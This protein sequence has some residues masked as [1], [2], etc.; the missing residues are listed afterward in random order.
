M[1]VAKL[2][3]RYGLISDQVNPAEVT[4]ILR[5]LERALIADGAVVEFGCYRGTTS[6]YI[7]RLLD[8]YKDPRPFHVYDSFEGL[9]EKATQ[10]S[11]PVGEQ[12]IKGELSV[13]KKEFIREF[14][15]AG[16]R[17]PAVH[18]EWFHD[19]T[20]KDIPEAIAFAFLDGDYYESIRDSLRLI[21]G[22]L[23][24]GAVIVVDDYSSESLPGAARA[25]DE[26]LHTNTAWSIQTI[27]SLAV[28]HSR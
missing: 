4:V 20:S 6:L 19:L 24:P 14:Q 15:K 18:K 5:E 17:V 23:S 16:L 12:F 22:K 2:I 8:F 3:R 9:P 26:W 10:D 1:D 7:R 28:L 21:G 13:S 11:S 25:I 27:A